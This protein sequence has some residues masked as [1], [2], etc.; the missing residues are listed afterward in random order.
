MNQYKFFVVMFVVGTVFG[1]SA[2]CQNPSADPHNRDF[3]AAV[4]LIMEHVAE[5]TYLMGDPH[6]Y[7]SAVLPDQQITVRTTYISGDPHDDGQLDLMLSNDEQPVLVLS[8]EPE[9]DISSYLI[10]DPHAQEESVILLSLQ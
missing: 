4:P 8:G 3:G 1:G 7:T 9:P 2:Y 5:T 10:G 6:Q